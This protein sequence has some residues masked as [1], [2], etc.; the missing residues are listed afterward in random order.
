MVGP[1]SSE[2]L[3]SSLD[4]G[5]PL[6]LQNSDFN[7]NTT[8]SV[9]LTGTEN[10]RVWA[11][12]MKLAINT[13]NKTSFIDGTCVKS[14]YANSAPLLNQ[15]QRCNSIVLSWLLNSVSEDLFLGKIFFD[16][17]AKV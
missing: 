3:I 2:D 7:A 16:N 11:V 14:A 17:V 5:N 1:S 15:W 6:H 4:L 9:K 13:R 8:I 10:Y 12:A